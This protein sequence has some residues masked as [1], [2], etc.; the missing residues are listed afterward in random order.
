VARRA[1][2]APFVPAA[3]EQVRWRRREVAGIQVLP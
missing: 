3:F 1:L 2:K